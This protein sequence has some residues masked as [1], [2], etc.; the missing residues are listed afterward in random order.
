MSNGGISPWRSRA[1]FFVIGIWDLFVHWGLGHWD[2]KAGASTHPS[3]PIDVRPLPHTIPRHAYDPARPFT[4]RRPAPGERAHVPG[5]V[6]A[7]A[8]ERVADYPADGGSRRATRQ[9]RRG[10]AGATKNSA[11]AA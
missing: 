8:A 2:F 11:D 7:G 4:N 5:D 1:A 3:R 6:A 10:T 9:G